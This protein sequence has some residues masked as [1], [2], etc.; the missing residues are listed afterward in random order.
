MLSAAGPAVVFE[1][2]VNMIVPSVQLVVG[3]AV[4]PE[5]ESSLGGTESHAA[6]RDYSV[7]GWS[8][9]PDVGPVH[10]EQLGC[11]RPQVA[12]GG[13]GHGAVRCQCGGRHLGRRLIGHRVQPRPALEVG[14]DGAEPRVVVRVQ[15]A[16][17]ARIVADEPVHVRAWTR[18][19]RAV[20]RVG[21]RLERLVEPV[22][23]GVH[24]VGQPSERVVQ[25]DRYERKPLRFTV[26]HAP[27][28][29]RQPE[30]VERQP[31]EVGGQRHIG[32]QVEVRCRRL[33]GP[34]GHQLVGAGRTVHVLERAATAGVEGFV[35][36]VHGVQRAD[37]RGDDAG[38]L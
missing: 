26:V 36:D 2:T 10:R 3:T 20:E 29:Q 7:V 19:Y 21:R 28:V 30:I 4:E 12:H 23:V 11:V 6:D 38:L 22:E 1:G 24:S 13:V 5:L 31:P 16:R 35:G 32:E 17:L 37:A 14:G 27:L 15:C 34:H 9:E 33:T 18:R 25:A 8:A